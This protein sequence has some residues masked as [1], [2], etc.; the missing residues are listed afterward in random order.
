MNKQQK[1]IWLLRIIAAIV[2]VGSI[3]I[4]APWLAAIAYLKPL[5]ATVQEQVEDAVNYKLEAGDR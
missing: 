2:T 3:I 5:P 1:R 4:F